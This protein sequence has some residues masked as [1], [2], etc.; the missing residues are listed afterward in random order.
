MSVVAGSTAPAQPCSTW[1][2]PVPYLFGGLAS[3][4]CLV[5]FALLILACSYC[6]RF[7]RLAD[8]GEDVESGG[9]DGGSKKKMEVYEE[10]V[11]VIMAGEEMPTFLATPASIKASTLGGFNGGEG[12]EKADSGDKVK[13]E[14]RNPN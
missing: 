6:R 9:N 4:L 8:A 12:S 7:G 3:M 5:S 10:N 14:I 11:L 1:H 13:E 2:S